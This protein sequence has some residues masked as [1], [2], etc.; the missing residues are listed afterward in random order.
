VTYNLTTT[1]ETYT[2]LFTPSTSF[3]DG[4]FGFFMGQASIGDVPTKVYFDYVT[5]TPITSQTLLPVLIDGVRN[6]LGPVVNGA[7]DVRVLKGST[8]DPL[9]GVSFRDRTLNAAIPTTL[10]TAPD[11]IPNP[12][13]NITHDVNTAVVGMY[14]VTYQVTD[15]AG[16][17][18][19]QVRKVSVEDEAAGKFVNTMQLFNTDFSTPRAASVD[20]RPSG[21]GSA[22][23][24]DWTW[25]GSTATGYTIGIEN[26][27]AVIDITNPAGHAVWSPHLYYLNRNLEVGTAYEVSW[28][29]R[30]EI[31]RPMALRLE[32]GV[33]TLRFEETVNLTTTMTTYTAT[34][35]PNITGPMSN[36]KLA[37][38]FGNSST[39]ATKVYLDDVQVRVIA[40]PMA[41]G[42]TR[43]FNLFDL[44]VAVNGTVNLS[45]GYTVYN[46][47]DASVIA[48]NVVITGTKVAKIGNAFVFDTEEAGV[49]TVTYSITDRY[50]V[51]T[52]MNRTVTV[53]A[54]SA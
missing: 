48:A 51:V 13:I 29:A 19:T 16:V 15:A 2:Y 41:V 46:P 23:T 14:E 26:G 27:E 25:H 54:P 18:T 9:R 7:L 50:G 12:A 49:F 40:E 1:F 3:V 36:A 42:V 22:L 5:S 4:K 47:F 43:F 20:T 30:A 53:T 39:I 8:F 32:A 11:T 24:N 21:S 17:V 10:G 31:A 34:F 33:G 45:Q 52:T 6:S 44:T 35:V 38:T 28:K 37:F